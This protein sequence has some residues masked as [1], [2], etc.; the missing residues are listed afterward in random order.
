VAQQPGNASPEKV[1]ELITRALRRYPRMNISMLTPIVRPYQR[2]WKHTLEEMVQDGS[3]IRESDLT[4]SRLVFSYRLAE[5]PVLAAVADMQE[6]E[7]PE[8][9]AA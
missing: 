1:R 5:D 9:T 8:P 3:V 6:T 2:L 7:E 4:G